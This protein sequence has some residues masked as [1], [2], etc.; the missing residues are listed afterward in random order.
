VTE[1]FGPKDEGEY[2]IRSKAEYC[3][4]EPD[5]DGEC[6]KDNVPSPYTTRRNHLSPLR[7][8]PKPKFYT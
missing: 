8:H 1:D 5:D 3:Y 4:Q 7:H 6:E 2:G